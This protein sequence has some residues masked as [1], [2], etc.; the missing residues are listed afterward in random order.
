MLCDDGQTNESD[1]LQ[2]LLDLSFAHLRLQ[3]DWLISVFVF[4]YRQESALKVLLC[5]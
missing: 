3:V 5:G 2:L 1:A 4:A